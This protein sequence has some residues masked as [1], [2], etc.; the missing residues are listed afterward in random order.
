MDKQEWPTG[1]VTPCAPFIA[2][3]VQQLG[4]HQ[5][6]AQQGQEISKASDVSPSA[7]D[8]ALT[9]KEG[10][11][12]SADLQMNG[13]TALL[14]A[15]EQP[16]DENR[17]LPGLPATLDT[18]EVLEAEEDEDDGEQN[19]IEVPTHGSPSGLPVD[20][21]GAIAAMIPVIC[22]GVQGNFYPAVNTVTCFCSVCRSAA[23]VAG[24]HEDISPTD[25]EKHAGELSASAT[26]FL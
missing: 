3:F 25:F 16:T 20:P 9:H 24:R 13:L 26:P 10:P 22:N 7:H 2:P 11:P 19:R 14:Q 6:A 18:S 21:G 15:A 8:S 12:M 23:E 5:K 1:S 4:T 17:G